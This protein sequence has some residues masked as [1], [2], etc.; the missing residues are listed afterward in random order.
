MKKILSL[1]AILI[2]ATTV[3][4]GQAASGNLT[5]VV[6][7]ASGGVIANATITVS[8]M[9][10]GI[11]VAVTSD[12]SG[13]YHAVNL[14]PGTYDIKIETAGF[15]PF[16]LKGVAISLNKTSTEDATLSAGTST[17]VEVQAQASVNLD[18]TSNN[19]TTTFTQTEIGELPTTSS[20]FGA[21]NASLLAPNVASGGGVG[22]GTGPS[23]GGQRPRNNNY[24]IEGI[25]V[26]S[27]SVTGPILEIP[28]DAT[29]NFTLI[30][31]Q[32]S[33]EFGHSSGGQFDTTVISGANKFH[34]RAYE[35]FQN[36]NLN[37]QSAILGGKVPVNPRYDANRYGGQVGGPILRDK[38]FFFGNYQ[39]A[40]VG[41][42]LSGFVCVP[43]A[44]G[45]TALA[46]LVGPYGLN[47]NNVTQYNKYIP[48]ANWQGGAQVFYGGSSNTDNACFNQSNSLQSLSVYQGTTLTNG[49]YASGASTQIPLG[50][51]HIS[52]PV[53]S[54]TDYLTTSADYTISSKDSLRFRYLYQTQGSQ[55]T[56]ASLPQFYSPSPLK[57]HF[58]SLSYFHSFTP[59]LTNEVRIGYNR[60]ATATPVGS[61]TFPGL[62]S[63]PNLLFAGDMDSLQVGPD[64]NG[65]QSG[66]Q[67][68]YQ[69]VDNVSWT[70]GKHQFTFGFDGRKYISPQSFTQR[71]RGD[72]EYDYATEYFHDLAPTYFGQRSTGNFFYY[73]DQTA[74]YGYAN[75]T[76]RAT[77]K[78]TLN[79]GLRYEFTSVPT[80]ER[81]QAL[82][83]NASC[84]T[85]YPCSQGL[86]LTFGTPQPQYT[87]FAPRLGIAYAYDEKTSIRAGFG[88]AYDVIFDNIGLLSFP[89]QYSS[90]NSVN[91]ATP[92]GPVNPNCFA[93][94]G[95]CQVGTPNFL[96]NG[97]LPPG[98]GALNTYPNTTSGVTLQRAATSAYIPNQTVPY[99]ENWN[100]TL[101]RVI[102][103]DYTLEVQ[104]LGTR[105]IHLLQQNQI[106]KQAKVTAANQLTTYF[107]GLTY[108]ATCK[109][110]QISTSATANTLSAITAQP[111]VVPAYSANG[112]TSTITSY[113]PW[114]ASNY[115][116]LGV[117]LSRRYQ[118]GLQLNASY[119][120]SKTM[121]NGTA[122]VNASILTQRRAQDSRNVAADWALSGLSRKSRFTLEMV[123]N[124]PFFQHSNFLLKNTL[125]GWEIAPI[126]SYESPEF[127]TPSS[128]INANQNGD[129]SGISRTI[130]NG[131]NKSQNYSN[132]L[133]TTTDITGTTV[134]QAG[135][136][137][138]PVYSTNAT[139]TALCAAGTNGICAA[140]Q[141]GYLAKN[142]NAYYVVAGAGTLPTAERNTMPGNPIDNVDI[143][144]IKKIAI[145]ERFGFEFSA[146]A[147]NVF[148]HA[149]YVPGA[150]GNIS[151]TS[152]AAAGTGYINPAS[153]AF[154][155]NGKEWSNHSR[156][157]QLVGKFTF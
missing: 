43:T 23:V 8:N 44:A 76:Y 55:D 113:Q 127:V 84:S 72:Y 135:S 7:D 14:L 20:G 139:L 89:P 54:N 94:P 31:S 136:G 10:T 129:S 70:K 104:Y 30:T 124:E 146:E 106:N 12:K 88:L 27:K 155:N 62:D 138:V 85:A 48:A 35:Y 61:Y 2:F 79:Y 28:G 50:N 22:I 82:N 91:T 6:K 80:G 66:I 153:S 38:L 74:F 59:N 95:T 128:E 147:F 143:S 63:F 103:K 58:G 57:L 120:W 117:N 83:A 108:N 98:T 21:L 122:E 56:A 71:V 49:E 156:S 47:S 24:T 64:P 149:Q 133:T 100:L 51:Y 15:A 125:G 86:A 19:L 78:L 92:T 68:L 13:E 130:I 3:S 150:L 77:P 41:Q 116:G 126:Y 140:S 107:S 157:V 123:Y 132:N 81:A 96:A 39:R 33:P 105:G 26:N 17:S 131:A 34:G 4:F 111:N 9:A 154:D 110:A 142:P 65:P 75:D 112:F 141:V 29:A 118:H 69:L 90:T 40:T 67:N 121:D 145:T 42:S 101:Q 1:I 52:A 144:A 102:A 25:D 32:F 114:G 87:N 45:Q 151:G 137:V 109:C 5:G 119:T 18:T 36:R 93:S 60:Q 134:A 46:A 53:F 97:G 16:L 152:T 11:S 115:N 37:A 73:G 148:N 99:S